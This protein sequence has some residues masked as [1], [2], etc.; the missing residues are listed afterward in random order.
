M[1]DGKLIE[2]RQLVD[3]VMY[4]ATKKDAARP[5]RRLEFVAAEIKGMIDNYL[6]G[7]LG[8][9]ITYAK[10]ASGKV[11]NKEHWISCVEQSWYVFENG[12]KRG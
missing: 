2:L 6:S 3:E 10:E 5:L 1:D 9:V 12:V 8:E 11:K 4:A 7:E